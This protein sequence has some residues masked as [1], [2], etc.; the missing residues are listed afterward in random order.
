MCGGSSEPVLLAQHDQQHARHLSGPHSMW[1]VCRHQH[2]RLR[3]R[4][5][6][7]SAN[8]QDEAPGQREDKRI[9]RRRVLTPASKANRVMLPAAVRA[10]TR[11]AMPR[12]VGV[13]R[14]SNARSSPGCRVLAIAFYS[15][16]RRVRSIRPRYVSRPAFSAKPR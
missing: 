10:S 1:H 16:R 15:A 2:D 13:T 11:L 14:T 9:E 7:A 8:R 4:L 5:H 12:A 3:C 6:F